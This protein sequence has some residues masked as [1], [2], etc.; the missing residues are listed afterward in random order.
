MVWDCLGRF[1]TLGHLT[2]GSNS[3]HHSVGA[4]YTGTGAV[5]APGTLYNLH[6]GSPRHG[7]CTPAQGAQ[8]AI[9]L[10]GRHFVPILHNQYLPA[11]WGRGEPG[12]LYRAGFIP[13]TNSFPLQQETACGTGEQLNS[14]AYSL[15]STCVS[16]QTDKSIDG[17]Q[18]ARQTQW[19][20][21]NSNIPSETKQPLAGLQGRNCLMREI[22][23]PY[24][25]ASMLELMCIL[26]VSER[27]ATR[28]LFLPSCPGIY[29]F[30]HVKPEHGATDLQLLYNWTVLHCQCLFC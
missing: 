27:P 25:S 8:G 17:P 22:L 13:V 7:L 18:R 29:S 10:L 2:E 21:R 26:S 24:W 15:A 9:M 4:V 14:K 16:L 3:Y 19:I 12:L 6:T 30:Q 1:G 11:V 20:A 28:M 23:L 5:Q